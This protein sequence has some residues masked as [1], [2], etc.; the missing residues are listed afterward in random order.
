MAVLLTYTHEQVR[1]VLARAEFGLATRS[2]VTAYNTAE[3]KMAPHEISH[4]YLHIHL[5]DHME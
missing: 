1:D 3:L 5:S 4:R 2:E